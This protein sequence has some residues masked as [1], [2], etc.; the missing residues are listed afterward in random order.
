MRALKTKTEVRKEQIAQAALRLIAQHGYHQLSMATLADEVG[1]VPSAIYRHYPGKDHV[2]DAVL[3][4]ISSRLQQNVAAAQ[5]QPLE[6]LE[7]L[8]WLLQ[9][10]VQLVQNDVPIPRVIFSEEIF[11]GDL[12][13]RRRVHAIFRQYVAGVARLIV[14]GQEAGAIQRA[15][16]PDTLAMMFLG[17]VQPSAI[18]W[19]MSGGEFD[20]AAQVENAWQA[21]RQMIQ[22]APAPGRPPAGPARPRT[23]PRPS[24]ATRRGAVGLMTRG[25]KWLPTINPERCTGCGRCVTACGPQSLVVAGSVATLMR[26]ET[27]GSEEHCLAPCPTRAIQMEWVETEPWTPQGTWRFATDRPGSSANSI[28]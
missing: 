25:Y 15:L 7:R 27:C 1:V 21:F 26:P 5:R 22:S 9:S 12:K 2:L 8:H 10:H 24:R 6:A 14:A 17:L 3:D 16:A 4:L 18:L 19:L 28:H 11:T 20:L 13:R 23:R